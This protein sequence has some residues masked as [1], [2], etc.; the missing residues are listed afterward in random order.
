MKTLGRSEE[1]LKFCSYLLQ[2]RFV[3]GEV[4]D[5]FLELVVVAG[6]NRRKRVG[7]VARYW[8][9]FPRAFNISLSIY[10]ALRS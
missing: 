8:T 7:C 10:F 4:G 9:V 2:E 1:G 3:G 5:E 6:C